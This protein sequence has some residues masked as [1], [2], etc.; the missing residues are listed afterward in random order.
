MS[1]HANQKQLSVKEAIE[2]INTKYF[3]PIF[4]RDY[5][6]G[7]DWRNC[8]YKIRLLFDSIMQGYPIGEILLWKAPPD[9]LKGRVFS[10]F[11]SKFEGRS[12][13]YSKEILKGEDREE[14]LPVLDGQQRLTSLLI[15]LAPNEPEWS[16]KY[17]RY[18][19]RRNNQDSYDKTLLYLDLLYEKNDED[20]PTE[21]TYSFEFLEKG[22][23]KEGNHLFKVRDILSEHFSVSDYINKHIPSTQQK[24][25]EKI[26][27]RLYDVVHDHE[28]SLRIKYC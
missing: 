18:R 24:G 20:E 27:Q 4:Q 22:E 6:W 11:I 13:A 19:G 7:D 2:N 3:L 8:G 5:V 1:E 10:K 15:G 9:A 12:P 23:T 16:Y 28:K 25:A 26:L 17:R 14:I 21:F